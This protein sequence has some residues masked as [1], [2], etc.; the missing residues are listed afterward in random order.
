MLDHAGVGDRIDEAT[1][2]KL[3]TDNFRESGGVVTRRHST[4]AGLPCTHLE[5]TLRNGHQQGAFMQKRGEFLYS[6]LVT[7][8]VRDKALLDRAK[9]GLRITEPK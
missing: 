4:L 2:A 1:Y 7:A 5:I 3:L 9:A 6:V 8:A